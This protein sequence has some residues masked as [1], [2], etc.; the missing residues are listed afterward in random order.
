MVTKHLMMNESQRM[1][2]NMCTGY[3]TESAYKVGL[4]KSLTQAEGKL[5][6]RWTMTDQV[7]ASKISE[8]SACLEES[9]R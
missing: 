6:G 3:F 1:T 2:C 5:R 7:Q 4:R 9:I 8:L